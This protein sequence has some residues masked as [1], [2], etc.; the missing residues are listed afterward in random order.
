MVIRDVESG[1]VV[2]SS[3]GVKW[4]FE[5]EVKVELPASILS[6]K[7]ITREMCFSSVEKID[8]FHLVQ[9]VLLQNMKIEEWRFEFGFVI[10]GSTN[11]WQCMIEAAAPD[12]MLPVAVLS[13][14]VVIE[15]CFYDSDSFVS[16]SRLRV[17][18]V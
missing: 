10:P 6:L 14:N 16:R 2:W 18:Y 3:D 8:H 9:N 1:S 15:T 11:T 5:D 13:G 17:Y 12:Q 4:D 7:A